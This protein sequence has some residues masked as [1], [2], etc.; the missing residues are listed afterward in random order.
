L[1]Q[2]AAMP[3]AAA[4][5][6]ASAP[7]SEP[8]NTIRT[9]SA[10]RRGRPVEPQRRDTEQQFGRPPFS[11]RRAARR[12]V[13]AIAAAFASTPL[14]SVAGSRRARPTAARPS[15]VPRSTTTRPA[16]AIRVAS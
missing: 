1:R 13:S 7:R 8:G 2:P 4:S 16:A 10:R 14:T 15:P 3:A 5:S 12:D 11:T 6:S 9:S